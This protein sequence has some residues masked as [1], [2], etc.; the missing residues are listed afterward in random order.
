MKI[1]NSIIQRT[2]PIL[3]T[4]VLIVALCNN[5]YSAA[6]ADKEPTIAV[7]ITYTHDVTFNQKGWIPSILQQTILQVPVS[8]A[9]LYGIMQQEED[10]TIQALQAGALEYVDTPELYKAITA[11]IQIDKN[12]T[13][14]HILSQCF[15]FGLFTLPGSFRVIDFYIA[16]ARFYR[17]DARIFIGAAIAIFAIHGGIKLFFSKAHKR[18]LRFISTLAAYGSFS[19][20]RH[21]AINTLIQQRILQHYGKT[22]LKKSIEQLKKST[23]QPS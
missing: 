18:S 16:E 12:I 22:A 6:D 4:T 5:V 13:I 14:G 20:Q 2:A 3:S 7:P 8:K 21:A 10:I 15:A 1:F 19:H 17:D 11:A 23:Q 9:L